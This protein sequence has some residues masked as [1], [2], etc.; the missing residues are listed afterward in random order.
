MKA[1]DIS[2]VCEEGALVWRG[3]GLT[4]TQY[5]ADVQELALMDLPVHKYWTQTWTNGSCKMNACTHMSRSPRSAAIKAQVTEPWLQREHWGLPYEGAVQKSQSVGFGSAVSMKTATDG[6]WSSYKSAQVRFETAK[7]Q[8]QVEI[9][10]VASCSGVE[11]TNY[12]LV[13][14]RWNQSI[15]ISFLD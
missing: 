2:R 12:T 8:Q 15:D 5:Q 7:K 10:S 11:V 1:I 4:R 9:R 6:S 14:V 3:V 13:P